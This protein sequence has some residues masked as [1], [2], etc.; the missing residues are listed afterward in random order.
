MNQKEIQNWLDKNIH[1]LTE[2]FAYLGKE[3]NRVVR[4]DDWNKVRLRTCIALPYSYSTMCTSLSA[5]MV[6]NIINSYN[7]GKDFLA[8]IAYFTDSAADTKKFEKAGVPIFSVESK[9]GL[10]EFDAVG[11]SLSFGMGNLNVIKMLAMSKIP[12]KA[13]DRAEND[14]FIFIGCMAAMYPGTIADG[15]D[16]VYVGEAEEKLPIVLDIIAKG[17][18]AKKTRKD[19]LFDI[20]TQVNCVYVPQFYEEQYDEKTHEITGWKK[21]REGVPDSV[22]KAYVK[23]MNKMVILDKSIVN[24]LGNSMGLGQLQIARGCNWTQCVFCAVA[25][26]GKPYRELN[27]DTAIAHLKNARKYSGAET[28]TPLSFNLGDYSRRKLL[29]K[30]ILEEVSDSFNIA[31]MRVD[32]TADMNYT[33]L[34]GLGKVRAISIGVEGTSQRMREKLNKGITREQIMQACE[35]LLRAGYS[36]VKLYHISNIPGE[37]REDVEE[38]LQLGRD[39]DAMKKRVRQE[40]IDQE[41]PKIPNTHFIISF[42]PLQA[43]PHCSIQWIAPDMSARNLGLLWEGLEESDVGVKLGSKG[44][45]D[46]YMLNQLMVRG[47]RRC[48]DA[49]IHLV[50]KTSGEHYGVTKKGVADIVEA[51]LKKKGVNYAFYFRRYRKDEVFPYDFIA[52]N[53]SKD[54]MWEGFQRF[55]RGE[56]LPGC[57]KQCNACGGCDKEDLK[58]RRETRAKEEPYLDPN[59]VNVIREKGLRQKM[60]A[61]IDFIGDSRW[62]P[63]KHW[64]YAYRR[65]AFLMDLPVEDRGPYAIS[66]EVKVNNYVGGRDYV[67][68]RLYDVFD[69]GLFD[70]GDIIDRLNANLIGARVNKILIMPAT[71]DYVTDLHESCLYEMPIEHP[72]TISDLQIAIKNF[73]AASTSDAEKIAWFNANKPDKD[74]AKEVKAKFSADKKAFKILNKYV[75]NVKFEGDRG[76]F[77]IKLLDLKDA[78]KS[79]WIISRNGKYYLRALMRGNVTI[80]DLIKG[81]VGTLQRR[82]FAIPATRLEY[83]VKKDQEGFSRDGQLGLG[84]PICSVCG[85]PIEE[86]LLGELWDEDKC[87]RHSNK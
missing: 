75:I 65:A 39:I 51:E 46:E 17:R 74:A 62:I 54:W 43:S 33:E 37:T 10:K 85:N 25:N 60:R 38:C 87:V 45:T 40:L 41:A 35:N 14:P 73:E 86:N 71:Q 79:V 50:L 63:A 31:S 80:Y 83:F 8:E 28:I 48:Y 57:S 23:D 9:H 68:F 27:V 47:D 13:V 82:M 49:F 20:T 26:C 78:V 2:P 18:E 42:T 1:T 84:D 3:P 22:T 34:T 72:L 76:A 58:I 61:Q 70:Q 64:K 56:E 52:L 15:L 44:Y 66:N 59:S 32:D 29:M 4:L 81:L 11:W 21:L 77:D 67:D 69:E 5:P 12:I 30:R 24:Y 19:I 6:A 53:S 36:K 16:F 7:G 55:E